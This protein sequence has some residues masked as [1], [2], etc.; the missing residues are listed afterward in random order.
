MDYLDMST[1]VALFFILVMFMTAMIIINGIGLFGY[2]KATGYEA[3]A[4]KAFIPYFNYHQILILA[5]MNPTLI[6]LII[7]ASVIPIVGSFIALYLVISGYFRMYTR[8]SGPER[9]LIATLLTLI[10]F[11]SV[12]YHLVVLNKPENI[13]NVHNADND[14]YNGIID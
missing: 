14:N 1:M 12:I 13:I 9:A 8:Y 2:F 5:G 7:F 11:A 10:P 3:Q 6:I 4:W